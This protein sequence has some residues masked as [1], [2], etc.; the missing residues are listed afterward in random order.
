MYRIDVSDFYDFQAFR[1]M[2][3]FRDYNKAVENLKRL[4]IYVDSAPEC[5]VMKEWD[6][7]FNKPRATIVSEQECRQKLKKIKVVQVG[8]KM[9][10]AWDIL[11][12]KLEDFSVR[13]IKFYTPSPNFYSI[14]T[15]YKYEQV[16]WTFKV[17][18]PEDHNKTKLL[19]VVEFAAN[20]KS[21]LGTGNVTYSSTV[22]TPVI[23]SVQYNEGNE[24]ISGNPY[25]AKIILETGLN[26]TK[27]YYLFATESEASN[28]SATS[29]AISQNVL[30]ATAVASGNKKEW[31]FKVNATK[32]H[33][34]TK[35]LVVVETDADHKSNLGTGNVTYSLGK[36]PYLSAATVVAE[37]HTQPFKAGEY[38]PVKVTLQHFEAKTG[39]FQYR[40]YAD[41]KWIDLPDD[42]VTEV[43]TPSAIKKLHADEGKTYLL[44][45]PA[46]KYEDIKEDGK[47]KLQIRLA[48]SNVIETEVSLQKQ[49]YVA[50]SPDDSKP[51]P[52]PENSGL[53]GGQKA[54]IVI[55]VLLAVILII[56]IIYFVFCRKPSK[57][58]S[59][60]DIQDDS[61]SGVNV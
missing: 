60:S 11:L 33:N 50:P 55:G 15:G 36:S 24:V 30:N 10:D 3:P 61:G 54:G 35:L 57:D 22:P 42:N 8:R 48:G 44:N 19:V 25:T 56:L 29:V 32:D 53:T 7:V 2:C 28:A 38:I 49:Q 41:Q 47:V 14:F 18:A 40:F 5:Y 12:S 13:G 52:T 45:I 43:E 37:N 46:P 51:T 1:N 34:K 21:N 31:T 4:V 59:S 20:H 26:I 6:V 39:S 9:L 23:E 16:E 58:K 17:N 27:T